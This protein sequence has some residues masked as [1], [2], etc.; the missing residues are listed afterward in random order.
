MNR[1]TN[2]TRYFNC[3]I[4]ATTLALAACG[5]PE[6]SK[7]SVGFSI[8]SVSEKVGTLALTLDQVVINVTSAD[9]PYPIVYTWDSCRDCPNQTAPPSTFVLDVPQGDNRFFQV[10][11][12]Y[13]NDATETMDLKYGDVAASLTAADSVI[14]VGVSTVG[15]GNIIDGQVTGRILDREFLSVATGPTSEVQIKYTPPGKP[16]MIVERESIYAGWFSF[17]I[18]RGVMLSYELFDGSILFGGPVD[19]TSPVFSS[20]GNARVIKG[21]VPQHKI[22]Q[23]SPVGFSFASRGP[24]IK[25]FGYFGDTA[26]VAGKRVCKDDL[27]STQ[28]AIFKNNS[29]TQRL[30]RTAGAPIAGTNFFSDLADYY[31]DGGEAINAGSCSGFPEND[32]FQNYLKVTNGYFQSK[33]ENAAP[34][35]GPLRKISGNGGGFEITAP[36]ASQ[37]REIKG[38]FLPGVALNVD[39]VQVYKAIG[40]VANN[41]QLRRAPCAAIAAGGVFGFQFAGSGTVDATGS[42]NVST[43][44]TNDDILAGVSAAVCMVKG[45]VVWPMGAFIPGEAFGGCRGCQAVQ[46]DRVSASFPINK[47]EVNQCVPVE[48]IAYSSLQRPVVN[49]EAIPISVSFTGGMTGGFYTSRDCTTGNV[50]A[51]SIPANKLKNQFYFRPTGVV[52]STMTVT[53]AS[54]SVISSSS[55]FP[56]SV[57]ATPTPAPTIENIEFSRKNIPLNA[58]G[59]CSDVELWAKGPLGVTTSWNASWGT[60]LALESIPAGAISFHNNCSQALSAR[61]S[62]SLANLSPTSYHVPVAVKAEV[63]S[64]FDVAIRAKSNQTT[65][66]PIHPF[67]SLIGNP[68]PFEPVQWFRAESSYTDSPT[69]VI[70]VW[71][72]RVGASSGTVNTVTNINPPSINPTTIGNDVISGLDFDTSKYLLASGPIYAD[73]GTRSTTAMGLIRLS[74]GG[75]GGIIFGFSDGGGGFFK[76]GVYL[77]TGTYHIRIFDQAGGIT[78]KASRD[79][80]SATA[81]WVFVAM[82]RAVVG[83]NSSYTLYVNGLKV[84]AVPAPETGLVN[85]TSMQIGGLPGAT[86]SFEGGISELIY[87][88]QELSDDQVQKTYHFMKFKYPF[89]ALP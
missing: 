74:A 4:L 40:P 19:L 62:T 56:L 88:D 72:S 21:W 66:L 77:D 16:S 50:A 41:Y 31:V 17:P 45:P 57:V 30:A 7:I 36:V 86:A 63:P 33:D 75:D 43:T 73:R 26:R 81:Q 14:S 51:P 25:V 78:P 32:L 87:V 61:G 12:I 58:H 38:Q 11:A 79:L 10:L 9:I 24:H 52:N 85:W 48:F 20:A 83:G 71:S 49:R 1:D 42:F 68:L 59:E 22:I 13:R 27:G 70:N 84:N 3:L 8:P 23:R 55:M 15:G 6:N 69:G 46:A 60:S 54:A 82:K 18:L 39:S 37:H 47:M 64:P 67:Y 53:A 29:S 44:I 76:V 35:L 2:S 89:L 34:F 65:P 80:G 28:S 5:R